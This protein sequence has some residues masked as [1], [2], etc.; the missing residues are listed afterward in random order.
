MLY[1]LICFLL[2]SL[3]KYKNFISANKFVSIF[4]QLMHDSKISES[5]QDTLTPWT[6]KTWTALILVSEVLREPVFYLYFV[7]IRLIII[8]L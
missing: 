8:L 6:Q 3:Q 4:P 7:D 5:S 1:F 2:F